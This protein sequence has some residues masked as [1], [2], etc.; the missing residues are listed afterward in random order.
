MSDTVDKASDQKSDQVWQQ[1]EGDVVSSIKKHLLNT[2]PGEIMQHFTKKMGQLVGSYAKYLPGHVAD[3]ERDD[4]A[5]IAN[6]ELFETIKSWDPKKHDDIWPLAYSRIHGAMR[7]HIRYITK[8]DPTRFQDWVNE[9]AYMY[10]SIE[11][12]PQFETKVENGVQLSEAMKT[13]SDVERKVILL[14][15]KKDLTFKEIGDLIE[16]SESQVSRIY[17]GAVQKL[18]RILKPRVAKPEAPKPAQNA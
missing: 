16:R 14:H 2:Y 8:S 12:S 13:L 17:A 7:D 11:K 9:A 1:I 6:I 10:L 4:L 3:S 5:N 15:V 18:K